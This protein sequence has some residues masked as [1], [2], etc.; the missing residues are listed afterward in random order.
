MKPL[1]PRLLD[2]ARAARRYIVTTTVTGVVTAALVI[3]QAALVARTM[4]P[5]IEGRTV[6]SDAVGGLV[7]KGK[8]R[9]AGQEIK[10][11]RLGVPQTYRLEGET[12]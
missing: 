8:S 6:L 9:F 4:S 3:G 1:D 11:K 12:K 10:G 7:E 5:V 2:H